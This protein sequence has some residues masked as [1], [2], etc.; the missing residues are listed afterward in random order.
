MFSHLLIFHRLGKVSQPST[1][2]T[3]FS[4]MKGMG[5]KNMVLPY[6]LAL[7]LIGQ[8]SLEEPNVD[9][10][11]EKLD[12]LMSGRCHTSSVYRGAVK[13][14]HKGHSQVLGEGDARSIMENLLEF[15]ERESEKGEEK[16]KRKR[17]VVYIGRYSR[18]RDWMQD[19]ER[20]GVNSG[21]TSLSKCPTKS[22]IP[23][24]LICRGEILSQRQLGTENLVVG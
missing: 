3:G 11:S 16:G 6:P 7:S 18:E 23:F 20:D 17:N 13:Q 14:E 15:R 24:Q 12:S 22:I 21:E 8:V 1:A 9:E 10:I 4:Y 19:Q 2:R 5:K